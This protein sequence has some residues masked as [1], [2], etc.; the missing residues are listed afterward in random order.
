MSCLALLVPVGIPAT[1]GGR[2]R[3]VAL[4]AAY[5]PSSSGRLPR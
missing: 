1:R 2:G 3:L 4:D 5:R